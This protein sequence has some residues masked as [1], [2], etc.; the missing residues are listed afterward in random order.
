MRILLVLLLVGF[1]LAEDKAIKPTDTKKVVDTKDVKKTATEPK[2]SRTGKRDSSDQEGSFATN[3]NDEPFRPMISRGNADV[4]EA[5]AATRQATFYDKT[6]LTS[7]TTPANDGGG[8]NNIQQKRQHQKQQQQFTAHDALT[9]T[10]TKDDTINRHATAAPSAAYQRPYSQVAVAYQQPQEQ[11]PSLATQHKQIVRVV[12]KNNNNGIQQKDVQYVTVPHQHNAAA[13]P[14]FNYERLPLQYLQQQLQQQIERGHQRPQRVQYIIAIPMSYLRQLQQQ[15]QQQSH[16]PQQNNG[17]QQQSFP[18]LHA[19]SLQPG[20]TV[21]AG[22]LARDHHGTYRPVHRF[23]PTAINDVQQINAGGQH[24][25]Q[26]SQT[27]A[28]PGYVTQYIQVPASV[29]LAAAQATQ[30]YQSPA[31]AHSP[32]PPASVAAAAAPPPPQQQVVY[33]HQPTQQHHQQEPISQQPQYYYYPQQPQQQQHQQQPQQQLKPAP[34]VSHVAPPPLPPPLYA[35]QPQEQQQATQQYEQHQQAPPA[36]QYQVQH[37]QPEQLQQQQQLNVVGKQQD[38]AA[39]SHPHHPHSNGQHESAQVV[40]QELAQKTL[41]PPPPPAAPALVP[42]QTY[43]PVVHYNPQYLLQYEQPQLPAKHHLKYQ[44][45]QLQLQHVHI[46]PSH[47]NSN[48]QPHPHAQPHR[49]QLQA[50]PQPPPPQPSSPASSPNVPQ[51]TTIVDNLNNLAYSQPT[52]IQGPTP[53]PYTH[54]APPPLGSTLHIAPPPPAAVVTPF[55]HPLPPNALQPAFSPLGIPSKV[56][57]FTNV[58]LQPFAHGHG[59][60]PTY[61]TTPEIGPVGSTLPFYNHAGG[62]QYSS[63]LYHPP[64]SVSAIVNKAVASPAAAIRT[65]A[66]APSSSATAKAQVTDGSR[67]IVKYP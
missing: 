36:V 67:T 48:P 40:P 12:A 29:L 1:V 35:Y 45:P 64:T 41:A 21:A 25:Q 19:Y 13:P 4:F 7:K 26:P 57:S 31:S 46:N 17:H 50:A 5:A 44:Q 63:H 54:L 51:Q 18:Q 22:P 20:Y 65:S 3:P 27:S 38:E 53:V 37:L 58:L 6:Q 42:Q 8:S 49:F 43:Q 23:S 66:K 30:V 56:T 10:A 47:L 28:T 24:Q 15:Q 34:P 14:A 9:T 52:T 61:Q 32:P 11:Q 2:K 59:H 60:G 62:L 16:L 33:H 39:Y 55:Y